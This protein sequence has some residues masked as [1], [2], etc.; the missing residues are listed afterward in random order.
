MVGAD[1]IHEIADKAGMTVSDLRERSG[2]WC[3]VLAGP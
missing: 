1:V 3:A 2:R